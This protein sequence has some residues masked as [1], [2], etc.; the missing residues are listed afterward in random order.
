M[1]EV[2][3]NFSSC[4]TDHNICLLD[5]ICLHIYFQLQLQLHSLLVHSHFPGQEE[6]LRLQLSTGVPN[7]G[8]WSTLHMI[9]EP[10]LHQRHQQG[11]RR[12]RHSLPSQVHHQLVTL[13]GSV[14]SVR[15]SSR[16]MKT[17]LAL[18]S[19]SMHISE[20]EW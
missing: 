7:P 6:D 20:I 2:D 19:M 1:V 11:Q 9:K 13:I 12:P 3:C 14:R 10:I 18:R 17:W 4:A 15:C 16:Q 8:S 5:C